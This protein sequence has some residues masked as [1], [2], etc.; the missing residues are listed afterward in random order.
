MSH[1]QV[2]G[3]IRK[4][5]NKSPNVEFLVQLIKKK[6]IAFF[7]FSFHF[8]GEN[9]FRIEK[10]IFLD[11]F[12]FLEC[13]PK[14]FLKKKNSKKNLMSSESVKLVAAAGKSWQRTIWKFSA[15]P[16]MKRFCIH[17]D[18]LILFYFISSYILGVVMIYC[19]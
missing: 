6:R 16:E 3:G 10:G 2:V 7:F 12:C 9:I 17:Q 4:S 18:L 11:L 5:K 1:P 14:T 13:S 19:K 8:F 15:F